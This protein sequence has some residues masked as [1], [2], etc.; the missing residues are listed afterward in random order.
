LIRQF[1]NRFATVVVLTGALVAG[2]GGAAQAATALSEPA[3]SVD[4]RPAGGRLAAGPQGQFARSY[5]IIA[6]HNGDCLMTRSWTPSE[7]LVTRAC[8]RTTY[9]SWT[10]RYGGRFNGSDYYEF[11]N[12]YN[13][14]CMDVDG[15]S[16]SDWADVQ[17]DEC[18]GGGHANQLWRLVSVGGV[19]YQL[20]ALH[21]DMCLDI[22]VGYAIQY[23]CHNG[24]NQR[25]RFL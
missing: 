23:G 13:D 4:H 20:V 19:Y 24:T 21:S 16:T 9:Q 10:L 15:A 6:E 3:T 5:R 7:Q 22:S 1:L 11:V 2:I 12:G 18:V 25:F 14:M 17:Q 8:N